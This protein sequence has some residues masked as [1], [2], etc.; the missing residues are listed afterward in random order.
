MGGEEGI[1]EDSLF[2]MGEFPE[3]IKR[4]PSHLFFARGNL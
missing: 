2:G 1:I 3:R 4:A